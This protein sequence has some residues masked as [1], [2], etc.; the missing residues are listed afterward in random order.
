M[1]RYTEQILNSDKWIDAQGTVNNLNDLGK[2]HLHNILIHIYKNRDRY[3]LSCL[4]TE[5]INS[6]Q[7]GDEFF[8][9]V[10]QYSTLW[11]AI[12]KKLDQVDEDFNFAYDTGI[13][14]EW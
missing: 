7:S 13:I 9:K 11:N 8:E 12:L 4:Q 3:W 5:T 2:G 6:Y 10:I 14:K 1:G